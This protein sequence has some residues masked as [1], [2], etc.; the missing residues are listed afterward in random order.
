MVVIPNGAN[1][2]LLRPEPE[3]RAVLRAEQGLEGKFVA[4]YAG[5]HG[6]AQGLETVLE[7]AQ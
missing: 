5:I 3:S 1:T 2:E 6:V 4:V 7:A